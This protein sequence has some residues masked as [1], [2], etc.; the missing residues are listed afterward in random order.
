MNVVINI[1]MPKSCLDCEIENYVVDCPCRLGFSS[2]SDYKDKRHP[3]CPLLELPKNHG[4]LI[5][6]NELLKNYDLE[7][8]TKYGNQTKEQQIHSYDTLM[9]YEIADMIENAQTVIK[10]YI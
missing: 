1:D 6:R 4:D 5:D 2:A 9:M 3:D 7:N 8:C 10:G